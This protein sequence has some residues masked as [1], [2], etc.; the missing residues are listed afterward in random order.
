MFWYLE[1]TDNFLFNFFLKTFEIFIN[2]KP[3]KWWH[4]I[5]PLSF[6]S[7]IFFI[8]TGII[9]LTIIFAIINHLYITEGKHDSRS[10][11]DYIKK[12]SSFWILEPTICSKLK[13]FEFLQTSLPWCFVN[14]QTNLKCCG[15]TTAIR[16][17]INCKFFF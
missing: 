2:S 10:D 17:Y 4:K 9:I 11:S 15:F 13:V 7:Y 6:F 5:F 16:K 1:T 12:K 14:S 8:N 3:E